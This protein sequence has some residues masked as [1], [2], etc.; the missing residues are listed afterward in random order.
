MT[1][2]GRLA[3]GV[4]AGT[5]ACAAGANATAARNTLSPQASLR[6]VRATCA[7][8]WTAV[9]IDFSAFI[10]CPLMAVP[11]GAPDQTPRQRAVFDITFRRVPADEGFDISVR[12]TAKS[13]QDC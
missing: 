5:C 1:F 2:S 4:V 11:R 10:N 6:K 7:G 12:D 3:P 9:R 8:S 13:G